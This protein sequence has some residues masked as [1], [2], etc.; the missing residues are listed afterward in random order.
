MREERER[1]YTVTSKTSERESWQEAE[2]Y[3]PMKRELQRITNVGLGLGAG[4]QNATCA[5]ERSRERV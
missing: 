2:Q 5:H 3:E 1:N 4:Y